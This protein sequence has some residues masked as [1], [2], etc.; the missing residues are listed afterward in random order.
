MAVV[1]SGLGYRPLAGNYQRLGS[2]TFDDV[3][4]AVRYAM[5]EVPAEAQSLLLIRRDDGPLMEIEDIEA[6]FT[7]ISKQQV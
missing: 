2:R 4:S 3:D 1:L 5:T 7:E 6:R